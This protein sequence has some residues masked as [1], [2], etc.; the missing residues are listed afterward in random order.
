LF[1][2]QKQK[3]REELNRSYLIILMKSVNFFPV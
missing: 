3:T 1:I 2:E